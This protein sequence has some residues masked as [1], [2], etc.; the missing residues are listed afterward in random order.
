MSGIEHWSYLGELSGLMRFAVLLKGTLR[1]MGREAKCELLATKSVTP[2]ASRPVYSH[3]A[4]IDSP[5][6][7]P[8]GDYEVEFGQEVAITRLQDG[9]WQVARVM[10]RSYTEAAIFFANEARRAADSRK[11]TRAVLPKMRASS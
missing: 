9:C 3:C 7:L 6:D 5:A 2:G 8:E 4:V 10:P 1:G 11:T